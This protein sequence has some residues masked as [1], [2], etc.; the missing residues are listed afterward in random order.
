MHFALNFYIKFGPFVFLT[1]V[2]DEVASKFDFVL[3]RIVFSLAPG[4][5]AGEVALR[6]SICEVIAWEIFVE[7]NSPSWSFRTGDGALDCLCF[8]TDASKRDESGDSHTWKFV[9]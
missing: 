2:A 6:E 7:E 1:I 4:P 8:G 9:L 3:L 5:H